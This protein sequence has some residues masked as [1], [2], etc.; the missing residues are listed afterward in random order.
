MTF[1]WHLTFKICRAHSL[2]R[3]VSKRSPQY[4]RSLSLYELDYA[5]LRLPPGLQSVM[6]GRLHRLN[7]V[8]QWEAAPLVAHAVGRDPWVC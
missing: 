2:G 3:L 1:G 4:A 7:L 8:V 6:K 5:S